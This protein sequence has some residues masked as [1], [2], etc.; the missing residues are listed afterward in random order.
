MLPHL[1]LSRQ[2]HPLT[3]P[4][5]SQSQMSLRP[6]ALLIHKHWL[7]LSVSLEYETWQRAFFLF[8]LHHSCL[9]DWSYFW[10]QQYFVP[11]EYVALLWSICQQSRI[12]TQVQITSEKSWLLS[13]RSSFSACLHLGTKKGSVMSLSAAARATADLRLYMILQTNALSLWILSASFCHWMTELSPSTPYFTFPDSSS[14]GVCYIPVF[15]AICLTPISLSLL[16][17]GHFLNEVSAKKKKEAQN[18]WVLQ[19]VLCI[20]WFVRFFKSLNQHL[21]KWSNVKTLCIVYELCAH[22]CTVC[23]GSIIVC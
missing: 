15:L 21:V 12:Q 8:L 22:T 6:W 14:W 2:V 18:C 23:L 1:I 9:P 11:L 5:L 10:S 20:L 17:Q 7:R 13:C 3:V 4:A 16:C 19:I